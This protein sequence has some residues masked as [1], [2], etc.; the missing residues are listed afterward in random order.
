MSLPIKTSAAFAGGLAGAAALVVFHLLVPA[1]WPLLIAYGG[2]VLVAYLIGAVAIGN[3][4]GEFFRGFLIGVNAATNWAIGMVVYPAIVGSAAGIAMAIGVGVT[5]LLSTVGVFSGNGVF[6][7]LLGYM[8]WILPASWLVVALGFLFFLGS[9]LGALAVGLPGVEFFKI[10]KVV[11]DWTTGTL[12]LKG[13]WIANLN[14]LHTAFNMGNFA[15][16]DQGYDDMAITHEAGHTLNLA[17]FGSV[18][19]LIGAIDENVLRGENAFSECL[20]ESHVPGSGRPL[21]AM[22]A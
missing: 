13:G 4:G 6:Q 17:A 9:L 7:A 5:L 15:F 20:A 21:L 1:I 16:V 3:S 18:F 2:V 12:F 19:H 22:W 8:N 10:T 11:F 14:P